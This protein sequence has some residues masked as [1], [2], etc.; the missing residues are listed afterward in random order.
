LKKKIL[1]SVFLLAALTGFTGSDSPRYFIRTS[2]VEDLQ[3]LLHRTSDRIP[4]ISAH[5]GGPALL[6]PENCIPTFQ[7]TLSLTYAAIEFDVQ[8]SADD[9]L[10]VMH[11]DRLDRTS[12]GSGEVKDF[13]WAELR[14]LQLKDN[15]ENLTPHQIPTLSEV[16]QW[17]KGKTVLFLDSKRSVPPE[18]VV[19][20]VREARAEAYTIVITYTPE[21]AA[22]IHRL[23]PQLMLS[24]NIYQL[25]DFERLTA[26]DVPAERMVAFTGL[27]ETD[28]SLCNFLHEK[29]ISCIT[30]TMGNLDRK[31]EARGNQV[32]QELIRN[33]SDILSTDRPAA[34]AEAY[35]PLLPQK[36][37]KWRFFG[38]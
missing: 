23:H 33:G 14:K 31:A 18:R 2:S 24:V 11:D 7:H 17:A 13:T 21:K 32:Y 20:A 1:A 10:M 26:L 12:T 19:Q 29:G 4:L 16:L 35:A 5:R 27:S 36:S 22:Q 38:K 3:M 30:G 6:F 28:T 34:V 37:S 25:A 8:L 15:Q 9:S